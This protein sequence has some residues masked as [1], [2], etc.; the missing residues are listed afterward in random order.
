MAI[1]K[2]AFITKQ[3]RGGRPTAT[4]PYKWGPGIP[5]LAIQFEE[6]PGESLPKQE[7]GPTEPVLGTQDLFAITTQDGSFIGVTPA[8]V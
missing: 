6:I 5:S 1:R 3:I 8:I 4:R 7:T 2:P